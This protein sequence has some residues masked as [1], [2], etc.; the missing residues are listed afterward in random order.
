[1]TSFIAKF[2][3]KKFLGERLENNYGKEDPYFESV[4]ATRLNGKPSG[5]MK[6]MPKALPPGI[7]DHDGKV[8]TKVKRRAHRLDAGWSFLGIRVGWS[9]V[10]GI[11][12]VVGDV[13]DAFMALMVIRT[14]QQVEGGL[15]K[16]VNATMMFNLAL[17][18]AVGLVPFIGDLADMLFR[19]NTKNAIVL[20][21]FLRKKGAANLKAQG[22]SST[23]DN[24]DP[25]EFDKRMSRQ[26]LGDYDYETAQPSRQEHNGQPRTQE[27]MVAQPKK[28]WL[29]GG[30]SKQ[31]DI[32]QG[33]E[34]H[35]LRGNGNSNG[36]AS[37]R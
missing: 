37:R 26:I 6:K 11:I 7:S 21:E 4:P 12:P 23:H 36:R 34:R 16:T 32:E 9:S 30:R 35:E 28:S 1:M 13:L 8:L 24:T 27:E 18:F 25:V 29:G 2:V 17:D 10:I 19:A 22:R 3:A 15:P 20:E 14:C 33:H 5:K 31:Q